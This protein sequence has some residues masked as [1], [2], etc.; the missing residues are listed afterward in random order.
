MFVI[1]KS[2][3]EELSNSQRKQQVDGKEV[4]EIKQSSTV[5]SG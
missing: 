3:G 2:G 5:R 4:F 1:Q